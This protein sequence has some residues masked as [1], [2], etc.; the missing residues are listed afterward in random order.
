[1]EWLNNLLPQVTEYIDMPYLLT[2]IF[3]SYLLK[4]YFNTAIQ[5]LVK[6]WKTVYSVL[7]I[8][9]L[10]AIPYAIWWDVPLQKV[11]ITYAVGTSL[12]ELIFELIE[13]YFKKQKS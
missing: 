6:N 3:F 13:G 12:Y 1:M 2:I 11:L 10:V 9:A 5:K 4:R 8:S 7:I